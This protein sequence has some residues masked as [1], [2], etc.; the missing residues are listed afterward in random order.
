MKPVTLWI[1]SIDA[2][3]DPVRK[4]QHHSSWSGWWF[5]L[6]YELRWIRVFTA[7]LNQMSGTDVGLLKRLIFGEE[8]VTTGAS[9][10]LQ[11]V[12]RVARQMVTRFGMSSA[13][14]SRRSWS[15]TRQYISWTGH[16]NRA[17]FLEENSCHD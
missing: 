3:Y 16:Y 10:D 15:S 2:G 6:V 5:N 7:A 13:K 9:N 4:N 1:W 17:R 8:E 12:A 14:R 11:Q